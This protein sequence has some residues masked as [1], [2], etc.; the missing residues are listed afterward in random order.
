MR[1]ILAIDDKADNLATIVA[2]LKIHISDCVFFTALSGKE[3]LDIANKEQPDVILL[4]IIMPELN[5]YETCKKL[6]DNL[7]TKHIPVIMVTAIKTDS[8]SRIRGLDTGADAFLSKPIDAAELT[9]QVNVMLRIKKA[10]DELRADNEALSLQVRKQTKE[11]RESEEKYRSVFVGAGVGMILLTNEL[12]IVDVNPAFTEITGIQSK[13][14]IGKS[15]FDLAKKCVGLYQIPN[16][17]K[18]L[19]NIINN[20]QRKP[21]E[22]RHNNKN[23]LISIKKQLNG[24]SVALVRDVTEN[25]KEAELLKEREEYYRTLIENSSDVISILDENGNITYE[26]SSHKNVLGYELG[27]LIG[28]NVFKL[29]HPDDIERIKYQF[30]NILTK[31]DGIEKVNFKFLHNNGKWIYLEGTA[32]NLL[33]SPKVKGIVVNYRDV[34]ERKNA[35]L[36]LLE[37]EL[38]LRRAIINSPFPIMIHAE[39]GEVVMIS[40][41]WSEITG[42]SHTEISTIKKWVNK[43]YVSDPEIALKDINELYKIKKRIYEGDYEILTKNG[44]K[45]VWEFMSAPLGKLPDG[46]RTV[47]S[48]AMDITER[49]SNDVALREGERKMHTLLDNLRGVAYRC[50]NDEEW[51]IEFISAG[52]EELTGYRVVDV[53]WNMRKSFNELIFHEDRKMVREVVNKALK[54]KKK[55]DI[56]YRLNTIDGS[57]KHVK[58]KGVGVFSNGELIAIEGFIN[59]ISSEVITEE[60][61]KKSEELNR[62]ITQSAAD[63]IITTNSEHKIISWNKAAERIFGYS[64]NVIL[65][66]NFSRLLHT[67]IDVFKKFSLFIDTES[68]NSISKPIFEHKAIRSNGDNFPIEI[69]ISKWKSNSEYYYTSIV[70]D[71]S[72]RKQ[73]EESLTKLSKA[74]DQSPSVITITDLH[75]NIDYVNPKFTEITGYKFEEVVNENTRILKSDNKSKEEY[76]DLWHTITSGKEWHGEFYNMKKNGDYYWESASVSPIF[77]DNNK[78]TNYIKIGEDITQRK[79]NELIQKALY[80][81]S[82]AVSTA[83]NLEK[84]INFIQ[85]QLNTIIDTSNFFVAFYDKE[86]DTFSSPFMND[87][88]DNYDSWPAGKTMSAY[89]VR[90]SKSLFVDE[91][92]ILQ[93]KERGDIEILGAIPKVGMI[94]PIKYEGI[95]NGVFAIQNYTDSNAYSKSDLEML[96]FVSD[97]I[98]LYINR[99]KALEKL[100]SALNKATESDRL[101]TAFL[102]NVSHEIR[103]PMNGILGFTSLLND[104]DLSGEEQQ[105]YINIITISGKRML[106]TLNDLMDIS[107]LETGQVKINLSSINVNDELDNLYSFFKPELEN[108]GMDLS[109]SVSLEKEFVDI[110]TDRDKFYAILSN[111]IKNSIKYSKKGSVNFGYEYKGDYLEFFVKDTGIG[112]PQNRQEAIFKRFVQADIEDIKVYEGSGLGLSISKAYVEMLGGGI[113]VNS[114]EGKGSEFYFTIPYNSRHKKILENSNKDMCNNKETEIVRLK[115][116]IVEDEE[117]ASEY[118]SIILGVFNPTLLFARTGIEAISICKE[119]TDIDLVLMDIKMPIMGGYEAT[120][121]IREFN[122]KV[123]IIAQTAYALGGDRE[124][125]INAGCD[126]YVT[127]PIDS[128]NLINKIE[129]VFSG[130]L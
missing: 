24:Q 87:E 23:L 25:K 88:K 77:D 89:V 69:S 111:L 48:M 18:N 9:A 55:F 73:N 27:E 14:V 12:N 35:E 68:D 16:L 97:L 41:E 78:I 53:E 34:T 127:K 46:R 79:R 125:A 71:I 66:T 38:R 116:L 37:S 130:R 65:N 20:I 86:T 40:N 8:K 76:Q 122:K 81:I 84:L 117:I 2:V 96:D 52:I 47:I 54:A 43:V 115:I 45:R 90:T 60:A 113:W 21:F 70:R 32:K 129:S 128:E 99:I 36:L 112:I 26:S 103:T 1:K 13:T 30:L 72:R 5:G 64:S 28:S 31:P 6:K 93:M 123:V 108:K 74:V 104:P 85:Q 67:R 22:I 56:V 7:L 50:K 44:E 33:M 100:K 91:N 19:K 107:M 110:N 120:R 119:N 29:V 121:E 17:L 15:S 114:S 98:S 126:D 39:N 58:E 57:I 124:K 80:N 51:T 49:N 10:E 109:Y 75:G 61:L 101:K 63:A 95:T 62:S 92:Q 83:D 105:S 42:Y 102:Q 118:L 82:N 3:G 59:D 106:S 94:V 4:D 11:L